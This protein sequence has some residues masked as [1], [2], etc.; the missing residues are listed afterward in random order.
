MNK[1]NLIE[2]LANFLVPQEKIDEF[3]QDKKIVEKNKNIYLVKDNF[4]ENEVHKDTLLYIQLNQSLPSKYLLNF[5][6]ENTKNLIEI[7]NEKQALNFTYGKDL[8]KDSIR[9]FTQMTDKKNYI[10][11]YQNKIVGYCFLDKSQKV[12]FKNLMNIGEYLKEN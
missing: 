9:A 2:F 5:I 11:L 10:V 1:E 3:L 8:A 6:K 4:K 7:K 12:G